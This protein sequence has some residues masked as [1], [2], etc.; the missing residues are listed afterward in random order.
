MLKLVDKF[1]STRLRS[2]FFFYGNTKCG[3]TGHK[4]CLHIATTPAY[5]YQFKGLSNTLDMLV[6]LLVL[7]C[8]QISQR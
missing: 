4:I 6:L 7:Y 1:A 3:S 2:S 5:H 8:N